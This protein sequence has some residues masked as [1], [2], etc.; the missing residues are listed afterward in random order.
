MPNQD[1][2]VDNVLIKL[3]VKTQK[4]K[5]NDFGAAADMTVSLPLLDE[6]KTAPNLYYKSIMLEMIDS[7]E[8]N[9]RD[10]LD[11]CEQLR[12]RLESRLGK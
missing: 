5:L 4:D 11:A 7:V 9:S 3:V 8:N 2:E 1:T 10:E 6:A 12:H